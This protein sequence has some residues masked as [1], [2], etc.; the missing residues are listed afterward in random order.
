MS[1]Y[2]NENEQLQVTIS[3]EWKSDDT[4]NW[5][6]ACGKA[7]NDL[8]NRRHH[9]RLCG[10]L[11]CNECTQQRALIPPGSI[12]LPPKGGK[13]VHTK[14]RPDHPF[15]SFQAEE[16]PDRRLTFT[17]VSDHHDLDQEPPASMTTLNGASI[18]EHFTNNTTRS[19]TTDNDLSILED[20]LLSLSVNTDSALSYATINLN[21]G[22]AGIEPLLYGKGLEERLKLAREPLRVCVPCFDSLQYSQEE[23]RSCNSNA[24]KYNSVNPTHFR[25]LLN[26]PVAFTLGHEIRKAAYTLHNLLP[27]PKRMGAFEPVTLGLSTDSPENCSDVCHGITGNFGNVDGV[28]IPARLLE[29][30]KGVAV[31]TVIKC[32]VGIAGLEL[33]TGLVVSRLESDQWS[34]P[35]AIG[36]VSASLGALVG[37]QISDHVFLLMTDEAVDVMSSNTGSIQLGVD[38]GVAVGPLGR[39][40]EADMAV[41]KHLSDGV[42]LASIYTYS[43]SKGLYAGISLDG[44]VVMTRHEVNERFY[45]QRIDTRAL[46][47][48]DVATPPAAQ[49]LYDA[50]KRCHVYAS[51]NS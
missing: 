49:P 3:S 40:A 20:D 47:S 27:L 38:I 45:G 44:K 19:N 23:L 8:F 48:G 35:C 11:F 25:R 43:L 42:A 4:K 6:V 7:F 37:A 30:A 46:L 50:L 28:R 31:M 14:D 36:S 22:E 29:L 21:T 16:D 51:S 39:S 15:A 5:C 24:M 10:N 18:Q 34:P 1:A 41:A 32:G 2:R 33:G 12:V 9:C 13:K 17:K 26:S